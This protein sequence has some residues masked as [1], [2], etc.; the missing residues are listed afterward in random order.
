MEERL[1]KE[2]ME[3][4][5]DIYSQL[6]SALKWKAD[7]RTL[8]LIAGMYVSTSKEFHLKRYLDIADY[9]KDN[10]GAFSYLK[11]TQRFSIAATLDTTTD[12]PKT[13]FHRFIA[14]YEKL[15]ENGFSRNAY[16]YI[17]ASTLLKVKPIRIDEIIQKTRDIYKGM[18]R[19]HFFLTNAGDYPLASIL[20]QCE[21]NSEEI[22]SNVEEYYQVLQEKG[23]SAGNDLQFLSHILALNSEY[24]PD[25][26]AEHCLE[27]KELLDNS[28]QKTKRVY[29]PY[30]GMLSFLENRE[31]EINSL[32]MINEDL[33]RDKLFK[34]NKEINFMMSVLLL[35]SAMTAIGDAARTGL[36]ISIETL[37]QAQQAAMTASITAAT[38]AASSSN[39]NT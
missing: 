15:I 18:K 32:L 13:N 16:S 3:A 28:K 38:V 30:I 21:K 7:K 33:N 4:Y 26:K 39:G 24:R 23:F 9:I 35:M 5:K 34:W 22:V 37:I 36:S 19:H 2:K 14:I 17:S 11:S 10:V 6:Y 12:D 8:M 27:I 25:E 1:I 31:S 29:Y 20:A